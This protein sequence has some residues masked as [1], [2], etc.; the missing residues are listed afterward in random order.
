[1]KQSIIAILILISSIP[2]I[3][4][5]FRGKVVDGKE[6]S[7][8]FGATIQLL[9]KDM[10][11]EY[12]DKATKK[13]E[14]ELKGVKNGQ[15]TIKITYVGYKTIQEGLKINNQTK[16]DLGTYRMEAEDV[17]TG[18]VLVT[19]QMPIGEMKEDTSQFNA[20][21]YK[22]APDA[23]AED[24]VK[25]MPGIEVSTDGTIKA[26]GETIKKV[27]VDGKPFFGDDPK[28]AMKNLPAEIIDKIQIYDKASDNAEFS[29]VSDGETDKAI[30]IITKR[31]KRFG[32]IGK[33]SA[34]YGSDNKYSAD[35]FWNIMNEEARISII[36]LANN[37]SKQNFSMEDIMGVYGSSGNRMR[38][39]SG[40]MRPNMNNSELRP[41]GDHF[42]NVSTFMVG[43]SDGIVTTNSIGTN[44]SDQFGETAELSGSYFFNKSNNENL[45]ISN[46]QYL[47]STQLLE[48]SLGDGGSDNYNHRFNMKLQVNL[49]SNNAFMFRPKFTAQNNEMNSMSSLVQQYTNG[50]KA[51]SSKNDFLSDYSGINFSNDL[52]YR[53]K[54]DTKDRALSFTLSN[55]YNDKDGYSKQNTTTDRYLDTLNPT[56]ATTTKTD[57][58]TDLFSKDL[59]WGAEILFSEPIFDNSKIQISYNYTNKKSES[60]KDARDFDAATN[61]YSIADTALSNQFENTFSTHKAGIGYNMK[62]GIFELDA[63]LNYQ[64]SKLNS[65]QI[66]PFTTK[67]D[68]QMENLLPTMRMTMKFSKA[69]SWRLRY[70]SNV[71]SPS[72]SQLQE[73]LDESN[74]LQVYIGNSH[75]RP[76]YSHSLMSRFMT[77]SGD[78]TNVFMI[79]GGVNFRNDYISNSYFTNYT[80]QDKTIEGVLVKAGTQLTR[81]VNLDGYWDSRLFM[82]YGFPMPLIRSNLN[83]G[84]GGTYTS[85]P[86]LV[87]GIENKSDAWALNTN[88]NVGSNISED[89]DFN[90]NGGYTYNITNSS[91]SSSSA[92]SKYN[93]YSLNLDLNWTMFWGIFLQ[94]KS[95]NT[96]YSGANFDK[97][98]Y[99]VNLLNFSIGKK[100][101][102]KNAAEIKL[103][104][105]DALKSNKSVSNN[106]A[107]NY[108]E[109]VTNTIL[110]Q[111]VMLSFSYNLRSF[112]GGS[113]S[114]EGEGFPRPKRD[115]RED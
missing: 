49:D 12:Y 50:D 92:N 36:G 14:F 78:M 11:P 75:L 103:T 37:V 19:A 59:G 45:Q 15:Y 62:E 98:D 102:P 30:N 7:P 61:S 31:D 76:Q 13:G 91:I 67:V 84:F 83:L 18:D 17:Q 44:Y 108:T 1:M 52:T 55:S 65:E 29:G 107:D 97:G 21:A 66:F 6:N 51:N 23:V 43:Q 60:D 114:K 46:K 10:K 105:F 9:N 93:T 87:N 26:Q 96:F 58:R 90:I 16:A 38:P 32:Q 69:T 70:R 35:L 80:G 71:I 28:M 95:I 33:V 106:T 4:A 94:A 63:G 39:P 81:P 20:Q 100:F 54:F 109:F 77:M 48:N 42:D 86:S 27:L 111:Y 113:G 112:G 68:Y 72:V 64:I 57:R 25:K 41:G 22:T 101:L 73:V 104:V 3:A 5:D 85:T 88:L 40:G 56:V 74:E 8:L 47:D 53:Y 110:K 34:G 82:N 2:A 79:F 115:M 89:L 24:L 99:D